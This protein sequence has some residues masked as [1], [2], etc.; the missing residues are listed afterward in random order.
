MSTY[1]KKKK[2]AKKKKIN[3]GGYSKADM[4][5]IKAARLKS[6]A[7][8]KKASAKKAPVKAASKKKPAKIYTG[9][10]YS[11]A[12]LDRFKAAR[13]KATAKNRGGYTK[14]EMQAIAAARRKSVAA[15]KKASA[16]KKP[17]GDK[18]T[19]LLKRT[20]PSKTT[21]TIPG[22]KKKIVSYQYKAGG[23]VLT[24]GKSLKKPVS[25]KTTVK[26]VSKDKPAKKTVVKKAPVS[27]RGKQRVA[28]K[29]AVA[30]KAPVASKKKKKRSILGRLKMRRLKKMSKRGT[31]V[32][33]PKGVSR[34]ELSPKGRIRKGA[35]KVLLTKG[36]AYASYEKGSKPA[37]SFNKAFK[38]GC[39]GGKK[40]FSWD[41]RSYS[42]KKK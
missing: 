27:V 40:S 1:V 14:A 3:R 30:K 39:A 38:K 42:C 37:K 6:V 12:D 11:K 31:P 36:G 19:D 17:A 21:K 26:A 18:V 41:G 4:A 5:R 13:L 15:K 8:K 29:K 34:E 9:E 20:S 28:K 35:K 23:P 32:T 33:K 22:A 24:P 10:Q 2:P 25:K 7:A 16:K